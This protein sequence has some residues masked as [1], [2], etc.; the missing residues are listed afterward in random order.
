M[1]ELQ[2]VTYLSRFSGGKVETKCVWL[3]Q[4]QNSLKTKDSF[5][6]RKGKT[7]FALD[8]YS[9]SGERPLKQQ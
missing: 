6:A 4:G 1:R 2:K 3:F 7:A 5:N 9:F 8:L